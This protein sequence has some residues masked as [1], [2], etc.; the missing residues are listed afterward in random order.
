MLRT[1]KSFKYAVAGLIT[2]FK[3]EPNFKIE[4]FMGVLAV[5]LSCYFDFSYLESAIIL[6]CVVLV[7]SGE[8]I[9]TAIEDLCN[10]VEP[11]KDEAIGKIKDIAAGFVLVSSLGA[12]IVGLMIFWGHFN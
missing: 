9:N 2:V 1:I 6:M 3:E 8:I 7:L 12:L 10:K 4:V 11:G 5:F